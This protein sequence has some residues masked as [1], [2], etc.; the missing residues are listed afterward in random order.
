MASRRRSRNKAGQGSPAAQLM[1][2]SRP[3]PRYKF[4]EYTVSSLASACATGKAGTCER[5]AAR[6]RQF[7]ESADAALRWQMA[8]EAF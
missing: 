1:E 6:W 7:D 5:D 2:E 4:R 3:P 8:E